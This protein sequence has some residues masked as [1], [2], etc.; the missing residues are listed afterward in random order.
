M[1]NLKSEFD[2]RFRDIKSLNYDFMLFENPY[3]V[4][5]DLIQPE[6]KVEVAELQL[7]SVL[8]QFYEKSTLI[9]SY[10]SLDQKAFLGSIYFTKDCFNFW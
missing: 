7:H 2:E 6:L 9:D 8:K 3:S 5:I 1:N 4:R 10:A